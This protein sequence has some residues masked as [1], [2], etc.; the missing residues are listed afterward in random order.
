MECQS[1]K[2]RQKFV[3]Q[4]PVLPT[5]AKDVADPGRVFCRAAQL[6]TGARLGTWLGVSGAQSDGPSTFARSFCLFVDSVPDSVPHA[7]GCLMREQVWALPP[8]AHTKWGGL[9]GYQ[10]VKDAARGKGGR[11]GKVES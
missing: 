10:V 4:N 1:Q 9:R 2:S 8:G 3:I 6:P 7:Q 5:E 11:T